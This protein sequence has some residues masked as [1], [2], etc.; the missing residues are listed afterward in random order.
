MIEVDATGKLMEKMF[1]NFCTDIATFSKELD[2]S[3]SYERQTQDVQDRLE[4]RIYAEWEVYG[5]SN[6]VSEKWVKTEAGKAQQA[7][8]SNPQQGSIEK[9][10]ALPK[11]TLKAPTSHAEKWGS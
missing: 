4:D 9:G 6:K 8:K 7:K 1:T 2:P 5:D 3:K 11:P 10:S